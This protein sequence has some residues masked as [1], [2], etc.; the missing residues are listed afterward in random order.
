MAGIKDTVEAL[1]LFRDAVRAFKGALKDG[2]LGLSDLP[3]AWDLRDKAGPAIDGLKNV[4]AEMGD[5]DAT[6]VKALASL[7]VDIG[8]EAWGLFAAKAA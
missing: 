6:E 4:P 1:V 8:S 2:K 3:L 5:L 7:L